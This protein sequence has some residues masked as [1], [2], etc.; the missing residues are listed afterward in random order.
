V[1]RGPHHARIARSL[2]VDPDVFISALDR[3]F[4]ARA[5]GR[6]GPPAAGLR[7]LLE[8][9]SGRLDD[10]T[11]ARVVTA[12]V[13]AV[14]ADTTLRRDA[15]EVLAQIRRRGLRTAVVSD[16]WYEMPAFLPHLPVA[17]L[18]D[19]C[20]YSVDVGHCKPHP[21]MYLTACARL[22]VAPE[23]CLYVGDGGSRELSGAESVG[24]VPLRLAAPDLA[25]H[26]VFHA[27]DWT[28]PAVGSLTEVLDVLDR[29]TRWSE[30]RAAAG[31][32]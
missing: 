16:C 21:A 9:L 26:L 12:R 22:G 24:I 6:Y 32:P 1:R 11:L 17:P 19:A 31:V 13:A 29:R 23:E 2:G 27:D 25:R 30:A 7:R 10:A 28:G 5:C 18:L 20:V 3:T 4:F 8:P 15:T 14:W